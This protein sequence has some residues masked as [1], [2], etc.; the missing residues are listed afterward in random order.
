[1]T[2]GE[3]TGSPGANSSASGSEPTEHKRRGANAPKIP[4]QTC[5]AIQL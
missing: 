1:M 3:V 2:P 4:I 5:S